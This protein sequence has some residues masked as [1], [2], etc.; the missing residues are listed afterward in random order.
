[1]KW[2]NKNLLLAL[3][4]LFAGSLAAQDQFSKEYS[5]P[6]SNPNAPGKLKVDLYN[7]GITVE[8]YSGKEVV[9]TMKTYA[10]EEDNERS[11]EG[12]R[13]IPNTGVEF[14]IVEDNNEVEIDGNHRGRTDF[15]V[16][17]P[18]NF[19]LSISTHHNGDVV[20]RNVSGE[21]EVDAHHGG[22][23]LENVSG[24]VVADTHHGGIKVVFNSVKSGSPM[25]FS[26][27]HG[28][29][30]ITFPGNTNAS[31]KMKSD[32]GDIFADFDLKTATPEPQKMQT[33]EGGRRKIEISSWIYA[34]IGSGGPEY[35]F[36]THHGDIIIR[37][38]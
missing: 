14:E 9:I 18:Q 38:K 36:T 35:M 16:K 26:T 21:I 32:R 6:L 1:M 11:K 5:I 25:A 34:N 3:A 33:T 20:V 37:K 8:G 17:V 28:D 29:V 23:E 7:G 31:A 27:Y 12:L 4:V 30:D 15:I 10:S 2:I 13:R 24:T 22:M 19:G